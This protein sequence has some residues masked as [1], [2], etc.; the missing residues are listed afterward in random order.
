MRPELRYDFCLVYV[1]LWCTNTFLSRRNPLYKWAR[2]PQVGWHV[3]WKW[4]SSASEP[5]RFQPASYYQ[6]FIVGK[7]SIIT[8]LYLKIDFPLNEPVSSTS[9]SHDRALR[10]CLQNKTLARIE[11]TS[12]YA[13][14]YSNYSSSSNEVSFHRLR[15]KNKR[16]GTQEFLKEWF[17]VIWS[18]HV[19]EDC[20]KRDLKVFI[21][22]SRGVLVILVDH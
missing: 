6:N 22:S 14:G 5:S 1:P 21:H 18:Q 13:Y 4:G 12:C 7:T 17:F 19:D 3:S 16:P 20:F 8:E 10:F 11:M 9:V 2:S 15:S